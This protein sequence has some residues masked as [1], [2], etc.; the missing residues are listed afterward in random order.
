MD[1]AQR[2][3][4]HRIEVDAR[5]NLPGAA[6]YRDHAA[7]APGILQHLM[8]AIRDLDTA[9]T[10]V[11]VPQSDVILSLMAPGTEQRDWTA[12]K[13]GE[14]NIGRGKQARGR[15]LEPTTASRVSR[16]RNR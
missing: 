9:C 13:M 10:V 3:D 8:C 12:I 2:R 14:G 5:Q 11:R 6:R 1:H 16:H 15:A 7:T 4:S